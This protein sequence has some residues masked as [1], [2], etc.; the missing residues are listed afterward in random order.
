MSTPGRGVW[1]AMANVV[2]VVRAQDLNSTA[3]L[4]AFFED[5]SAARLE[6]ETSC[7]YADAEGQVISE[8]VGAAYS[9]SVRAKPAGGVGP[10]VVRVGA[11]NVAVESIDTAGGSFAATLWVF[12]GVFSFFRPGS[13]FRSNFFF[14]P[15]SYFF[16]AVDLLAS[17]RSRSSGWTRASPT[18][19]TSSTV[20]FAGAFF[21]YSG[22]VDESR[23]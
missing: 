4:A 17:R 2:E 3:D 12:A 13:V 21:F 10:T 8:L 7:Q 9:T 14:T 6:T 15:W 11:K 1:Q 20:Y 23:I 16:I 22:R 19:R 5:D 18:T